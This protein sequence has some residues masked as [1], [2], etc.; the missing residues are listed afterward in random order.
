MD[1]L[2][3]AMNQAKMLL[4]KSK[5]LVGIFCNSLV[6]QKLRNECEKNPSVA[7]NYL[8]SQ[9]CF[10]GAPVWIDERLGGDQ[11]EAYYDKKLFEE[12]KKEQ[13]AYDDSLKYCF[14]CF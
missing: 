9:D 2:L 11:C 13:N 6:H 12:R 14:S 5:P 8:G 1:N 4:P 7:S 10:C 3:E